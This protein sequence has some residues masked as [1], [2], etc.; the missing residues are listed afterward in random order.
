MFQLTDHAYDRAAELAQLWQSY[1]SDSHSTVSPSSDK[2][3]YYVKSELVNASN[4]SK[5]LA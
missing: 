1:T 3:D 5:G 2:A 4:Q